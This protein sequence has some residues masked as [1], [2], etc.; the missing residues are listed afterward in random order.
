ML[1]SA[2][3]LSVFKKSLRTGDLGRTFMLIDSVG[4]IHS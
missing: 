2:G 4:L 3:V 1:V